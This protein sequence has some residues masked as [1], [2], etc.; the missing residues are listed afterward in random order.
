MLAALYWGPRKETRLT[1]LMCWQKSR[2]LL[3]Q[4]GLNNEVFHGDVPDVDEGEIS[5]QTGF[6]YS[7]K[8]PDKLPEQLSLHVLCGAWASASNAVLLNVPESGTYCF[9]KKVNE[10]LWAFSELIEVWDPVEGVVC[11]HEDVAWTGAR[12]S[13]AL[14]CVKRYRRNNISV[15]MDGAPLAPVRD[16]NSRL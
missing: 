1:S 9:E 7:W 14:P 2:D 3:T 8:S 10:Y 13:A 5:P 4:A 16:L 11:R 15:S 6:R 12:L